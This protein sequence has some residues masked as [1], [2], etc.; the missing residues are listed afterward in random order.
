MADDWQKRLDDLKRRDEARAKARAKA[1]AR[2]NRPRYGSLDNPVDVEHEERIAPIRESFQRLVRPVPI[3]PLPGLDFLVRPW[4][5]PDRRGVAPTDAPGGQQPPPLRPGV[6]PRAPPG[7][8]AIVIDLDADDAPVKS[9]GRARREIRFGGLGVQGEV[10]DLEA[11]VEDDKPASSENRG[12]PKVH[13]APPGLV[14]G[15]ID[16]EGPAGAKEG[17]LRPIL[18]LGK[19][20]RRAPAGPANE[21]IDIDAGEGP[22]SA[23]PGAGDA[24]SDIGR[25]ARER[26]R[27][28]ERAILGDAAGGRG[29]TGAG[30][31]AGRGGV[32]VHSIRPIPQRFE[33]LLQLR[34]SEGTEGLSQEVMD[35]YR[36]EMMR[37]D[38]RNVAGHFGQPSLVEEVLR[39]DA[40]ER[41]RGREGP[42]WRP[43]REL[44][45]GGQGGVTLWKT[46][47]PDGSVSRHTLSS[48]GER[49]CIGVKLMCV[50]CDRC[51]NSQRKT[52]TLG[53]SSSGTTTTRGT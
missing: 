31:R 13:F 8:G 10:I 34:F 53:T 44:G 43:V 17:A 38:S 11:L 52:W 20:T 36:N 12:G 15:V 39:E 1:K 50:V 48:K 29:D 25:A 33:Q 24:N 5:I 19:R 27:Q 6:G 21:N 2:P 37:R 32:Q 49:G 23:R 18:P 40:L 14:K 42:G 9:G 28:L 30:P 26:A 45:A 7:P 22:S 47:R 16:L 51:F 4:V 46:I 3:L 41:L 35:Y